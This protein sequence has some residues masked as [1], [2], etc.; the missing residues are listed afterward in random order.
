MI[1]D[2]IGQHE[3]LLPINHNYNKICDIL[4]F[5]QRNSKSFFAGT[6]KIHSIAC[7]WLRILSC[8]TVLL[9]LKSGQ[10]TANRIWEFGYSHD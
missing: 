10:L 5:F 1:T 9:V 3:V 7:L 8:F 4:E 6:E 2:Q